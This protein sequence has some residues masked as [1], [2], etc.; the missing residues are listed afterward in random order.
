MTDE[1][2]TETPDPRAELKA[3]DTV[4]HVLLP[5]DQAGRDRVLDWVLRFF[6]SG[7]ATVAGTLASVTGRATISTSSPSTEVSGDVA[8]LFTRANPTTQAEK[9]LVVAY[10]LQRSEG[11]DEFDAFSLNSQLTHL[12]H[13]AANITNALTS[14]MTLK[15]ALVVQTRKEGKTKQARKKYK[16]TVE[17]IRRVENMLAGVHE[18]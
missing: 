14:L 12:G 15:P 18:G 1:T 8:E 5:L 13:R 2:K 16:L 17:G 9:A 7:H 11:R 10:W 4:V 6:R 3:M